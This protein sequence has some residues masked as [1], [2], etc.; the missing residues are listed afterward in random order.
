[1][2]YYEKMLHIIYIKILRMAKR[3]RGNGP[4]RSKVFKE[5]KEQVIRNK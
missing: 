3:I 5:R 2:T 1:M 4:W